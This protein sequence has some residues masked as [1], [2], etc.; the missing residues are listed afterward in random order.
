MIRFSNGRDGHADVCVRERQC[1]DPPVGV[2]IVH[3]ECD[4]SGRVSTCAHCVTDSVV[5][6]KIMCVCVFCDVRVFASEQIILLGAQT[7]STAKHRH[8]RDFW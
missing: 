2:R 1:Q 3:G 8:D 6:L 5:D 4:C 7:S